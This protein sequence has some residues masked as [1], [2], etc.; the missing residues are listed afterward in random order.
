MAD[1]NGICGLWARACVA[2]LCVTLLCVAGCPDLRDTDEAVEDGGVDSGVGEAPVTPP[3][4]TGG[5][6]G[7]AGQGGGGS[8]GTD[9][10]PGPEAG[11]G[12]GNAA[13]AGVSPDA[14]PDGRDGEVPGMD[15]GPGDVD[16]GPGDADSGTGDED[17]GPDAGP[18]CPEEGA[19]RCVASGSAAREICSEGSWQAAEDCEPNEICDTSNTEEPG[20]CV[21]VTALCMGSEGEFICANGVMHE[22]NADAISVSQQSCESQAHCQAGLPS[23]QCAICIPELDHRCSDQTLEQ[24]AED[25][26]GYEEKE[27]CTAGAPCNADAGACTD[28]FCL[29]GTFRCSSGELLGCNEDQTAW[30][31]VDP[32]DSGICDAENGQ[33]DTCVAGLDEKCTDEGDPAVCSADGQGWDVGS[34]GA[35]TPICVG[36]G[37][38]VQCVDTGDCST[39]EDC[40]RAICSSSV[41]ATVGNPDAYGEACD[42]DGSAGVCNDAGECVGCND[43]G[44]CGTD[45]DCMKAICSSGDCETVADPD[46]LDDP[47]DND[48]SAGVCNDAG[49]CVGCND[50]DDCG[51]D[52]DC[53]KAICSSGDCETVADGDAIGDPC[54]KGGITGVCDDDGDCVECNDHDDCTDPSEDYCAFSIQTCVE[55]TQKNG[56]CGDEFCKVNSGDP[57]QN[58]CV[59]CIVDADCG[60]TSVYECLG[61]NTCDELCGNGRLD[62]GEQCDDGSP[63]E[64]PIDGCG[65]HCQINSLW[66]CPKIGDPSMVLDGGWWVW[67]APHP[68]PSLD[69]AACAWPCGE[70]LTTFPQPGLYPTGGCEPD[71]YPIPGTDVEVACVNGGCVIECDSD[72]DC[73]FGYECE[74]PEVIDVEQWIDNE[75]VGEIPTDDRWDVCMPTAL[76]VL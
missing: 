51:T 52:E 17:A 31:V 2:C 3:P 67:V 60:D 40:M 37:N 6:S 14:A 70:I 25:G 22:C 69:V 20:T 16:A 29:A 68:N 76:Y 74:N 38:C 73:P 4:G 53:M 59:E 7:G 28:L 27:V 39:D 43:S 55:C 65:V 24:C 62:P 63:T 58:E 42:N 11:G 36:Q 32:C 57:T 30:E 18:D 10:G 64:E 34:C 44:D 61:N 71:P 48:G 54:S 23:E 41:C 47:C 21:G 56:Q 66:G 5:G 13:D 35:S 50:S 45:E 46:A 33:C 75:F 19:L 12:S 26:M 49:E 1:M 72:S 8:G 15:S 9:P